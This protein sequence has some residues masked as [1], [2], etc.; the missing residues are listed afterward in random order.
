MDAVLSSISK[1]QLVNPQMH[2]QCATV[3]CILC[4]H[5]KGTLFENEADKAECAYQKLLPTKRVYAIFYT[6]ETSQI[7]EINVDSF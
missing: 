1:N 4:R 5:I 7:A 6:K 2:P 3:W